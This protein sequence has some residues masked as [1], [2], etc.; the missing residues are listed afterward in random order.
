VACVVVVGVGVDF[1]AAVGGGVA[2]F[3]PV[4]EGRAAV[5][6]GFVP[7]FGL[8]FDAFAIAQ[9]AYVS[10]IG[11]DGVEFLGDFLDGGHPGLVNHGQGYLMFAEKRGEFF[12]QPAFIPDFHCGLKILG[13]FFEEGAEAREEF[14]AGLEFCAIEIGELQEQRAEF[15][16]EM[17]GGGEEARHF[18]G[19]VRETFFVSDDLRDFQGEEE[20]RG[21]FLRPAFYGGDGGSAVEGGVHFDGVEFG[22]VVGEEVARLHAGG[23]ERAFPASGGEG[24]GAD[25][26]RGGFGCWHGRQSSGR[27]AKTQGGP[28]LAAGML[29]PYE[30]FEPALP[31][32][33][34]NRA[35]ARF[36]TAKR[37]LSLRS[38]RYCTQGRQDDG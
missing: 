5:E 15:I 24:G 18:G 8:L 14:G 22:G 6:D 35:V 28:L 38:L 20:V 30:P 11:G 3:D 23:V 13:K 16:A 7:G 12:V 9:P 26:D 1:F 34:M 31:V 29:S 21:S 33:R 25:A 19:A 2:V 10:E 36:T 4:G 17:F 27:G 37:D 32:L